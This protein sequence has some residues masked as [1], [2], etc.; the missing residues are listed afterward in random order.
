MLE[1]LLELILAPLLVLIEGFCNAFVAMLEL[2]V[3]FL[4]IVCEFV[5]LALTQ[6]VSAASK[7]YNERTQ[8]LADRKRAKQARSDEGT[9]TDESL[10]FANQKTTAVVVSVVFG[11]FICSVLVWE[12][13]K[14][15]QMQRVAATRTQVKKLADEFSKQLK[16]RADETSRTEVLPD[17]DAWEQ[18]IKLAVESKLFA[19]NVVIRSSGPDGI[20]DSNDDVTATKFVVRPT[21]QVGSE[22]KNRAIGRLI[23]GVSRL[24]PGKKK[25]EPNDFDI[26]TDDSSND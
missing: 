22:L 10:V 19:T 5:F 24:L 6:G 16:E 21:K 7:K 26:E 17:R 20:F 9:S 13:R 15:Q 2:V 25:K 23:E 4:S 18:P 12:I 1:A 3:I 8:K 14:D 11:V